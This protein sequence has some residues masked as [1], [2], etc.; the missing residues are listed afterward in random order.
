METETQ[1][2][3]TIS[4]NPA[5]GREVD[6]E[7]LVA[8]AAPYVVSAELKST[9]RFELVLNDALEDLTDMAAVLWQAMCHL[10]EA[11]PGGYVVGHVDDE[12]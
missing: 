4:Y 10:N 5:A 1:D 2:D 7:E 12:R 6:A 11:F 8:A 9:D 3:W